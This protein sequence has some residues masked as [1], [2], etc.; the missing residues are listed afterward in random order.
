MT[1]P[2]DL[3]P[4]F[5]DLPLCA[6]D[7]VAIAAALSDIA[8]V[9][10]THAAERELID[11]LLSGIGEDLGEEVQLPAVTPEQLS[12]QLSAPELKATF[13]RVAAML[14]LVDGQVSDAERQRVLGYAVALGF[15]EGEYAAVE[16][17][18]SKW[19]QSGDVQ[20]LFA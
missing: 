16:S 13:V 12:E 20:P 9:D 10:G 4:L 7:V 17:S 2:Q 8:A 5:S 1:T 15:S 11:E 19:M 6:D 3:F 14:T 18:I